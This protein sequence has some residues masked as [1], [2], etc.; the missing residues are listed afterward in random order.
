M[1]SSAARAYDYYAPQRAPRRESRVGVVRGIPRETISPSALRMAR[2]VI[3]AIVLFAVLAFV[4]IGLTTATVNT[5]IASQSLS[6][7]IEDLSSAN[8]SLS[9]QKSVLSSPAAVKERATALGMAAK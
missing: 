7:Q 3:V 8:A 5:M 9:V 1:A 4:R 2:I 6:A